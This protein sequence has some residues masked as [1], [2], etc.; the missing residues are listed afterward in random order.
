MDIPSKLD[1]YMGKDSAH[2][3]KYE[4]NKNQRVCCIYTP[5]IGRNIPVQILSSHL[6]VYINI[7]YLNACRLIK[8]QQLFGSQLLRRRLTGLIHLRSSR[9]RQGWNVVFGGPLVLST[10]LVQG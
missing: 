8:L 10:P 6:H 9:S 4:V 2:G 3:H 7:M 5:S 1:I